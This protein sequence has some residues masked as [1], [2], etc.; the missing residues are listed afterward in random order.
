MHRHAFC[1]YLPSFTLS[2]HIIIILNNQK[3]G[4]KKMAGNLRDEHGNPI[5]LTDEQGHPV[6]LTDEHGN[7]IRLSGVA[8]SSSEQ[9]SYVS[10]TDPSYVSGGGGGVGAG[11]KYRGV[12]EGP[13][14]AAVGGMGGTHVGT[15]I[16]DVL[17]G[18]GEEAGFGEGGQYQPRRTDQTEGLVTGVGGEIHAGGSSPSSSSSEGEMQEGEGGVEG[19]RRR[20]KKGFTE[21]I[22]EKLTGGKQKDKDKEERH[23]MTTTVTSTTTTAVEHHEDHGKKGMLEKI[24]EKLPGSGHTSTNL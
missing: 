7:P 21:K 9:G 4:R 1:V 15:T 6:K 18:G 23:V 20:K 19:G 11:G 5:E 14:S 2:Q 17:H 12:S 13:Y 16:G 22:K 8:Y 3:L 24:K 10:H